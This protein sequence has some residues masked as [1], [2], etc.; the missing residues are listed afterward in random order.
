MATYVSQGLR[1]N[2]NKTY[3]RLEERNNEE[4]IK[5]ET[6][7]NSKYLKG[8]KWRTTTTKTTL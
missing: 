7:K 3:T 4:I 5:K 8:I 6:I 1:G 2:K